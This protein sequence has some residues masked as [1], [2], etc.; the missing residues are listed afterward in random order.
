MM[1]D[2]AVVASGVTQ[3]VEH[4]GG[5]F[6]DFPWQKRDTA[7]SELRLS[8]KTQHGRP[9]L[10][11]FGDFSDTGKGSTFPFSQRQVP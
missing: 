2:L 11:F 8:E 3:H 1:T 9:P 7:K 10:R 5:P 6:R 4:S